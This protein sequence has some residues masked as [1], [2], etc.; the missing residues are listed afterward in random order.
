MKKQLL[1]G[2]GFLA[3]TAA[4]NTSAV[5][6]QPAPTLPAWSWT[7]FY[8][9]THW[10]GGWAR[11]PIVDPVFGSKLPA[12]TDVNSSGWLGG[13]QA[14][15]NW[16]TGQWVGGLELDISGTGIK[17]SSSTGGTATEF[18]VTVTG[19]ATQ[20]D[21]FD[22]IGSGRLR[23]GY[24]PW[25][26]VLLY[27]TGGLAWARIDQTSS[28]TETF[29]GAFSETGIVSELTPSWRYGWVAGLGAEARIG[30]TNWLGRIE[31]LHYDFGDSGANEE[32]D[33]EFIQSSG[34]I[35]V[36]AVRAGL[37]YKFGM[38]GFGPALWDYAGPLYD[39]ASLYTKAPP[40]AAPWTWTG[41]YIGGHAGYG[42]GHDPFDPTIDSRG[43]LGGVQA[44]ANWQKGSWVGGLELDQSA[45]GI[46][47]SA[48]DSF[49]DIYSD[50]FR[51]LGSARARLGYLVWPSMLLY[52]TV[53][54]AWTDLDQI[55]NDGAGTSSTPS[56]RFGWV[57]GVGAE[58]RIASTNWI[59]RIEY[60]HYDFG[61]S[62]SD[63][64]VD[65]IGGVTT[66]DG[67]TT[68][69]LTADVVRAGVSY[70]FGGDPAGAPP[71][72]YKA[73]PMAPATWSGFYLG[74]HG[75]YG[76][77]RDPFT[78]NEDPFSTTNVV[79]SG[80]NSNGWLGGFQAGVNRQ[81]D[82]WVVGAE[83]DLSA[84]GIKGS[85]SGV[86]TDGTTTE[87]DAETDKF[88][89]L[90][91]GRARLGFLPTPNVLLYGTGGLAW[92][93]FVQTFGTM[94]VPSGSSFSE[95]S[96]VPSWRWGWVAGI[97]AETRIPGSNWL[98]RVEYLHYD[99]GNTGSFAETLIVPGG[100]ASFADTT[101][102]L[103]VDAVRA[104]FD[105]QLR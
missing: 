90:G 22:M 105:Y 49:G 26:N 4:A 72:L 74:A 48:T 27:G 83:I 73:P 47:G 50:K 46:K 1:A 100:S 69:R 104:G 87:T 7:G 28:L 86:A 2:V 17:G 33:E 97:G 92:T 71:A 3:L 24:L 21:K 32:L 60:L 96:T 67:F 40:A 9:G 58:K 88:D 63:N 59:G 43:V 75:G 45:T 37:S 44:G 14:G 57:A 65:T 15:A 35:T 99:F 39:H 98:A 30:N 23:L 85:T 34:R 79:L 80:I 56:R 42:W 38:S 8:L 82:P 12:I 52:G 19:S 66:V 68:G 91:S 89:Y 41:F 70:K 76:W 102:R 25:P 95:I 18:G 29:T 61:D 53:G 77:G 20:A 11:D 6:A 103:T 55:F 101:G 84:T 5:A 13:F 36:D 10:G 51:L 62:G 93:R 94:D 31:Y 64:T 81:I 54:L 78:T 16:Q